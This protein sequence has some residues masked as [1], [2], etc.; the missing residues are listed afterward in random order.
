MH[1]PPLR[2]CFDGWAPLWGRVGT[3]RS[4]RWCSTLD[5]W[6]K[7]KPRRWRNRRSW[8][9][10]M[11]LTSIENNFRAATLQ[12]CGV[13]FFSV[14]SPKGVVK[15]GVGVWS[16]K[17]HAKNGAKKWKISHKFHSAAARHWVSLS[18]FEN[19]HKFSGEFLWTFPPKKR[20]PTIPYHWGR[21]HYLINSQTI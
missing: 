13:K 20:S 2:G 15:I 1:P 17:F 8:C 5:L 12:K 3:L 7:C 16:A 9:A 21:K 11:S 18:N 4:R 10:W 14:F 19:L 6:L